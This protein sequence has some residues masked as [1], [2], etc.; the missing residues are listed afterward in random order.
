[1]T[2][3]KSLPLESMSPGHMARLCDFRRA[4][5]P[6]GRRSL[7]DVLN[8][9]KIY[10]RLGVLWRLSCALLH[11]RPSNKRFSTDMPDF[12]PPQGPQLSLNIVSDR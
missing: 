11:T 12:L 6:K 1:M 4:L 2:D 5:D 7:R 8:L 9:R 10:H 3:D